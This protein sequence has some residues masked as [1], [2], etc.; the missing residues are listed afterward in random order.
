LSCLEVNRTNADVNALGDN[1][2]AFLENVWRDAGLFNDAFDG[3]TYF[4]AFDDPTNANSWVMSAPGVSLAP[5][6]GAA[7]SSEELVQL[8]GNS[9][10]PWISH[11]FGR[12]HLLTENSVF[13]GLA[14][15]MFDQQFNWC[16][17]CEV[18]ALHTVDTT[19]V[20][21][22][23]PPV[24]PQAWV[25]LPPSVSVNGTTMPMACTFQGPCPTGTM[26]NAQTHVCEP[27]CPPG[28]HFDDVALTCVPNII[29]P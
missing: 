10:L 20:G 6:P 9:Y 16:E 3:V 5:L 19:V 24:C 1:V 13:G 18:F 21:A 28:D 23:P 17:V 22:A 27:N 2:P 11:M 29:I 26:P 25:G 15:T 7:S 8:A 12:D 14:D 4:T